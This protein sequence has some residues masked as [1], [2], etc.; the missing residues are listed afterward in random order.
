[1]AFYSGLQLWKCFIGLDSPRYPMRNYGDLGF[2]VFG[3]WARQIINVLQSAQFFLN[4][5]LLI[6]SN[7]QGLQQMAAGKN[8]NGVLCCKSSHVIHSNEHPLT[9]VAV[10][11]AEVIFMVCGF[12]LGQIRTLQ[13]L[14]FLANLAVWLNV[15]VILMT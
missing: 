2:R 5:T 12:F 11:A 14:G 4:V 9:R 8:G 15:F 13:R 6:E 1:M 7:G 3:G 10:V